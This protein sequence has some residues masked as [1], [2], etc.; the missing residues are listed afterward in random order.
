MKEHSGSYHYALCGYLSK[1]LLHCIYVAV[2]SSLRIP[3]YTASHPSLPHTLIP[4][5][6][7]G[8]L[9]C[10]KH[11][12]KFPFWF[13]ANLF[14]LEL[15]LIAAKRMTQMEECTQEQKNVCCDWKIS[16]NIF[17]SCIWNFF[18]FLRFNEALAHCPQWC[19]TRSAHWYNGIAYKVHL[20]E[21]Y[22]F[23]YFLSHIYAVIMTDVY[24]KNNIYY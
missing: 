2:H 3:V 21:S 20:K 9:N 5:Q 14:S 17:H 24:I 16:A 7:I 18:F 11:Q 6:W 4:P 23:N 19:I 15:R 1:A 13:H 8:W 12:C 22:A 10:I